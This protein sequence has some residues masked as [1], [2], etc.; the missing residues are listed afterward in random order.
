MKVFLK[1]FPVMFL[2]LG[3]CVLFSAEV[4]EMAVQSCRPAVLKTMMVRMSKDPE[5][6]IRRAIA[7]GMP[8]DRAGIETHYVD[9][10]SRG[11]VLHLKTMERML[12]LLP[13]EINTAEKWST[14]EIGDSGVLSLTM[15][16][17]AFHAKLDSPDGMP[18]RRYFEIRADRPGK[19]LVSTELKGPGDQAEARRSFEL[20]V[21]V[22]D[23]ED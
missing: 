21:I 3:T 9:M 2:S 20:K 8:S 10:D 6:G 18:A 1:R 19:T 15:N 17:T 16:D 7:E 4:S 12:I 22:E 11:A 13:T 14:L 23:R 5:A